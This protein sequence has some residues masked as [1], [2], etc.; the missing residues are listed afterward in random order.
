MGY[1]TPCDGHL[2][3]IRQSLKYGLSHEIISQGVDNSFIQDL[4]NNNIDTFQYHMRD[5]VRHV[6]RSNITKLFP[7]AFYVKENLFELL[8]RF[9]LK[10]NISDTHISW[11]GYLI[12]NLPPKINKHL[13]T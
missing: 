8:Y 2:L 12:G 11:K 9:Y 10:F 7:I 1:I 3:I 6:I 13:M 4:V 5:R